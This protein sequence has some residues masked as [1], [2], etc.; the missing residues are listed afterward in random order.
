MQKEEI[1]R[2]I[3]Q[4]VKRNAPKQAAEYVD[5]NEGDITAEVC[6]EC[7]GI[8]AYTHVTEF[9]PTRK[10]VICPDCF[11]VCQTVWMRNWIDEGVA[12]G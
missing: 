5:V 9:G 3:E 11:A 6:P 12:G 4:A 2:K 10:E 1:R 7:E 8:C